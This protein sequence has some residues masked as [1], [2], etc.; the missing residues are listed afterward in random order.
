MNHFN[1]I[2]SVDH[3]NPL[4]EERSEVVFKN[5]AVYKGQWIGEKKHGFGVQI[6]PDGARY[7]GYW[8]NN[9]A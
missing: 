9:K 1:R 7:E 2:Y 5:G 3:T 6:W 4:S 8:V